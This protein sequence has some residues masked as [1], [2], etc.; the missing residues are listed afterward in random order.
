[1]NPSTSGSDSSL[2]NRWT[3]L[4]GAGVTLVGMTVFG[5]AAAAK[6]TNTTTLI[7]E[8]TNI[9]GGSDDDVWTAVTMNKAGKP[10]KLSIWMTKDAFEYLTNRSEGEHFHLDFPEAP[11]LNYTFAGID[12]NPEG[13]PPVGI[14]SVPHFDL[15][16]FFVDEADVDAI[17]APGPLPLVG[18]A[19]YDIPEE[20]FPRHYVYE[21]PRFIVKNMGEHIYNENTPEFRPGGEF[22]H[23]YIYGVYDPSIDLD[24]PDG[25]VDLPIGPDGSTVSVNTYSGDGTGELTFTE[26]MVTEEF[27]RSEQFLKREEVRVP[28]EMPEVFP[29]AGYYP[30]EYVMRYCERDDA[31]EISLEGMEWFES[32]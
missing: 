12:W 16:Y 3:L 6:P 4:Q 32:H 25:T 10:T 24:D 14:W 8:G 22:T 31:Y 13:H 7:G 5:G 23:T 30:T 2:I 1:M 27:L 11:G 20:Q 18:V 29:E 26:P 17:T 21:E 9:V 15:H 28:V 19:T